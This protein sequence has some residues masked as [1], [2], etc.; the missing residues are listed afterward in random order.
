[1]TEAL[2]PRGSTCG[3]KSSRVSVGRINSYVTFILFHSLR[4]GIEDLGADYIYFKFEIP[5][6]KIPACS[7]VLLQAWRGPHRNLCR[8]ANKHLEDPE[9]EEKTDSRCQCCLKSTPKL[10]GDTHV[11]DGSGML[12]QSTYTT[13]LKGG[14]TGGNSE[15]GGGNGNGGQSNSSLQGMGLRGGSVIC[16][17]V[18]RSN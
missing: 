9:E 14:G 8:T 17:L 11:D 7:S 6:H 10:P 4:C 3:E 18:Q 2:M 1:M 16:L 15:G 12:N 13:A 5:L